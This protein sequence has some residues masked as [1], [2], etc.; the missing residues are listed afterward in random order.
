MG[1]T[2]D[3][4]SINNNE[5]VC[6]CPDKITKKVILSIAQSLY[7]P[8]GFTC[9]IVLEPKLLLRELWN[10]NTVWDEQVTER[11]NLPSG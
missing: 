11:I 1:Q 10:S 5:V 2:E 3:I 8:I 9:P 7:D 4:L 6:I